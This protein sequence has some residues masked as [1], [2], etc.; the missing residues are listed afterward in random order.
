[1]SEIGLDKQELT[2]IVECVQIRKLFVWTTK[3]TVV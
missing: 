1:M 3:D 2:P